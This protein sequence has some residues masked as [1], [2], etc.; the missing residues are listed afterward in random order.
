VLLRYVFASSLA[1]H[2]RSSVAICLR[3]RMHHPMLSV[4]QPCTETETGH[5]ETE[6]GHSE[7]ET[8]HRET[9]TG[10][11]ETETGHSARA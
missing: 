2:S 3:P 8:G 1:P 10:H 6:T 5:R 4:L 9:E 11:S 7:T